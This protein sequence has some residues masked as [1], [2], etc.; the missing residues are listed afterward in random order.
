ML[1][2]KCLITPTTQAFLIMYFAKDKDGAPLHLTSSI[3]IWY[4]AAPA[5]NM[6][7]LQGIACSAEKVIGCN[8]PSLQDLYAPK[9]LRSRV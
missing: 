1:P 9:P 4:A 8:L 3:S 5:E 6:G 2:W 7:R